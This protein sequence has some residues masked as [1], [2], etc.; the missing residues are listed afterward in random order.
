MV[1][2]MSTV[3]EMKNGR[4]HAPRKRTAT[5]TPKETPELRRL[6]E[7]IKAEFITL[8]QAWCP[9]SPGVGASTW[10]YFVRAAALAQEYKE[11]PIEFVRTTMTYLQ[12]TG[13]QFFPHALA[14]VDVG[15]KARAR[16][17][18]LF[19]LEA[20]RY[21]AQLDKWVLQSRLGGAANT[22][23][24]ASQEYSP[25][26]RFVLASRLGVTDVMEECRLAAREEFLRNPAAVVVFGAAVEG[27]L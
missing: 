23:R 26:V 7:E 18:R 16:V 27:V 9:G 25:L 12:K 6:A 5:P 3:L 4:R 20:A 8:R 2:S 11:S 13:A 1:G 24:C 10:R 17:V 14:S 15:V 21:A 19:D 22:L